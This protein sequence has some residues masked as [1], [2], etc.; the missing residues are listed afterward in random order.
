MMAVGSTMR[1][2]VDPTIAN[3][4]ASPVADHPVLICEFPSLLFPV[5]EPCD[6]H[7]RGVAEPEQL[8]FHPIPS[9]RSPRSETESVFAGQQV[10][11]SPEESFGNVRP[12]VPYESQ[13]LKSW[14]NDRICRSGCLD[15]LTHVSTGRSL[16]KTRRRAVYSSVWG[17]AYIPFTSP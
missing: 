5:N 4:W 11:H 17:R 16:P 9:I 13:I 10:R 15:R 7:S 6:F 8:F 14:R 2:R 1:N 12:I 3:P